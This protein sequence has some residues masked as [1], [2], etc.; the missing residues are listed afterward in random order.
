MCPQQ[1]KTPTATK[2]PPGATNLWSAH[3]V[4]KCMDAN[5]LRVGELEA[6]EEE[7]EEVRRRR[8]RMRR[9]RRSRVG[10]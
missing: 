9:R 8:R 2:P 10:L 7:E 5:E 6:I 3:L 1:E 4:K